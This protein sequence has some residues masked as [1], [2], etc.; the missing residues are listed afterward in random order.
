MPPEK[1]GSGLGIFRVTRSRVRGSAS[2]I[3]TTG[4]FRLRKLELRADQ[5]VDGVQ[6]C[7]YIYKVPRVKLS[8]SV[9]GGD[10]RAL[11]VCVRGAFVRMRQL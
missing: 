6:P 11:I 9:R 1:S 3:G 10:L 4:R 8:Y 5:P 2:S 7:C